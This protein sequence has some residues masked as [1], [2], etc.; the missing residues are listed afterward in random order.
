[1]LAL[2]DRFLFSNVVLF[3]DWIRRWRRGGRPDRL[4]AVRPNGN[5]KLLACDTY[6][7]RHPYE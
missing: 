4:I 5:R 7:V 1:M 6:P 3:R 2:V